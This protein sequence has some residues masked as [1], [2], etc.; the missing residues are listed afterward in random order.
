MRR[1]LS[2]ARLGVLGLGVLACLSRSALAQPAQVG[3]GDGTKDYTPNQKHSL[4]SVLD[5]YEARRQDIAL[6]LQQR[7]IELANLLRRDD[8]SKA[9]LQAKVGEIMELEKERQELGI[10]ELFDAKAQMK[11]AQWRVFRDRLMHSIVFGSSGR[12]GSRR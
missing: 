11:P 4:S 12:S 7:K 3:S 2:R 9:T 1:A 6:R 5:R 10:D 8:P